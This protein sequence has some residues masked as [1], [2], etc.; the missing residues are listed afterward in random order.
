MWQESSTLAFFLVKSIFIWYASNTSFR[1]NQPLI[2]SADKFS[3][4]L[5]SKCGRGSL[6]LS[7]LEHNF[8]THTSEKSSTKKKQLHKKTMVL[9]F[10]QYSYRSWLGSWR[11]EDGSLFGNFV[12]AFITIFSPSHSLRLIIPFTCIERSNF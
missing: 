11:N 7:K 8:N 9:W 10:I 6:S 3:E 5:W 12:A 1:C 2:S 4:R